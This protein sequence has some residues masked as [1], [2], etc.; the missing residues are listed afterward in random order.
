L[1]A[2]SSAVKRLERLEQLRSL[3][4]TRFPIA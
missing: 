3:D 1:N 4:V 2:L